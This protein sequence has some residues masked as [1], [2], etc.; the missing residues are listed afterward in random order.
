MNFIKFVVQRKGV[1]ALFGVLAVFV[2]YRAARIGYQAFQ[3]R[4]ER[5]FTERRIEITKGENAKI[6][7]EIAD[8]HSNDTTERVAKEQLNLRLPD[9]KVLVVVSSLDVATNAPQIVPPWW[10][11]LFDFFR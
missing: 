6:L 4:S 10:M 3:L 5:M 2:S 7:N 11:R 1:I 9:E 8:A